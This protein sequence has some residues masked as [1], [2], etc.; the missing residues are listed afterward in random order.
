MPLLSGRV[1]H[2]YSHSQPQPQLL[3]GPETAQTG[4]GRSRPIFVVD[5][6]YCAANLSPELGTSSPSSNYSFMES[7]TDFEAI[8]VIPRRVPAHVSTEGGDPPPS[9]EEVNDLIGEPPS[10]DSLFQK[11]R[12]DENKDST[13]ISDFGKFFFAIALV[14]LVI[15]AVIFLQSPG[16]F[17]LAFITFVGLLFIIFVIGLCKI[18]KKC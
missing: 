5:P 16:D 13:I 10:Y 12:E 1:P 17:V 4:G 8:L 15:L 2:H 3:S 6:L 11:K 9:Y 7:R 14:L 18:F